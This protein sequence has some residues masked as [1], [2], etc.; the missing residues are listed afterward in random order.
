MSDAITALTAGLTPTA[1][2]GAVAGVAGLITIMVVFS[3]GLHFV[4]TAVKGAGK[5]KVKF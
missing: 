2:W 5:G 3:L 1:L 4:R